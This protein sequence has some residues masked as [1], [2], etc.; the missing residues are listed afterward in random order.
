MVLPGYGSWAVKQGSGA[1]AHAALRGGSARANIGPQPR[2][3]APSH[4]VSI[5]ED[6]PWTAQV[7]DV[8]FR[9]SRTVL[10]AV[11]GLFSSRRL[12]TGTAV[13]LRALE[14]SRLPDGARRILDL[15]CGNGVL[16][17]CLQR[18][19]GA[20]AHTTLVDRDRL[21]VAAARLAARANHLPHGSDQLA[22]PDAGLGYAPCSAAA[23][24][25][26]VVTNVPAKVGRAGLREMLFGGGRLLAPGAV[27]ACVHV[28]PLVAE[29]DA[30]RAREAERTPIESVYEKTSNDFR[31][32]FWRF[33]A[34]LREPAAG[35]DPLDPWRRSPE[36]VVDVPGVGPVRVAAVHDVPEFDSEHHR[37]ML[38]DEFAAAVAPARA[39][40]SILVVNPD[41]GLLAVRLIAR[42]SPARLDLIGRDVLSLL[43]AQRTI[44]GHLAGG[45]RG[46]TTV[47]EAAGQPDLPWLP[48][49]GNNH[50][51]VVGHL[52]WEEGPRALEF[53]LRALGAALGAE[54][55]L[56][57]AVE[58]G[59]LQ[60]LRRLAT[61]AGLRCGRDGS[62][63]R[64]AVLA[65]RRG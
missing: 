22:V 38:L 35:R 57:L 21:A 63:Q 20:A 26:L 50:D 16:G 46:A 1:R 62:R 40:E 65:M 48:L 7:L 11:N 9:R 36:P 33:P 51:L 56:V 29:I 55:R 60:Q 12:D 3:S 4:R 58:S 24:F 23:P 28:T 17:L 49:P 45:Q 43:A 64:Q 19:L 37:T 44:A 34:G 31:T 52:D 15:G 14:K 13:L 27:L 5:L 61:A 47:G 41:H 59:R 8:A 6:F 18:H 42:R 2:R 32:V 25:D 54:G 53:T 10:P 30:L 39:G